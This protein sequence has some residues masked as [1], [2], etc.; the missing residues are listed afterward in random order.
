MLSLC[1]D[2]FPI[3]F[4]GKNGMHPLC[5]GIHYMQQYGTVE[6]RY[7]EVLPEIVKASSYQKFEI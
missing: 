3:I 6:P 4:K 7:F 2:I 1:R 5:G